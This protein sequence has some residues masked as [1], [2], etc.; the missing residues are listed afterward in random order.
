MQMR[1]RIGKYMLVCRIVSIISISVSAVSFV[2][3]SMLTQGAV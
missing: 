1:D 2:L 3:I